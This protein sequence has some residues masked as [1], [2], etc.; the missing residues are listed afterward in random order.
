MQLE[1]ERWTLAVGQGLFHYE[2]VWL[3]GQQRPLTIIYDAGTLSARG[4]NSSAIASVN[5][6]HERLKDKSDSTLD[7][8][9]L[10]HFHADH[11]NLFDQVTKEITV[12]Y[13]IAPLLTPE[14]NFFEIETIAATIN[15]KARLK[16]S[17]PSAGRTKRLIRGLEDKGTEG[18]IDVL[19]LNKRN[20][21][22][23]M[24]LPKPQVILLTDK[25]NEDKS[26]N[27]EII[28]H[29]FPD[30]ANSP[31]NPLIIN[32]TQQIDVSSDETHKA[33]W[34]LAF[35]YNKPDDGF[36][37]LNAKARKTLIGL[38][39]KS[40]K[41]KLDD[42][43]SAEKQHK[44]RPKGDP[45]VEAHTETINKIITDKLYKPE[46]L[47]KRGVTFEDIYGYKD[48]NMTSIALYSGAAN[49]S[50][51]FELRRLYSGSSDES[52]Y[53][54][55]NLI[56]YSHDNSG[57]NK[58]KNPIACIEDDEGKESREEQLHHYYSSDWIPVSSICERDCYWSWMGLGD[59]NFDKD[60]L[61][62]K[63]IKH[64][65]KLIKRVGCCAAPHHGSRN[66]FA[67]REIPAL[68]QGAICLLSCDPYRKRYHHPHAEAMNSIRSGGMIPVLVT[69]RIYTTFHEIIKWK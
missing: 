1:V 43:R 19:S 22:E 69:K 37:A 28:V 66:G 23:R 59:L 41:T 25:P 36:P 2:E 44:T 31:G 26:S 67:T 45:Y 38:F 5:F 51:Q 4:K 47:L 61:V 49:L 17:W 68:M 8:L 48:M 7:Y 18:F 35:Y 10:S 62:K 16:G 64:F 29:E 13:F 24:D 58:K 34:R 15:D 42:Y 55:E 39:L 20:N 27:P 6:V 63:F 65:C 14:D 56:C 54:P 30:N 40:A 52:T 33:F 60:Q 50:V 3:F 12:R 32:H 11:F 21:R 46:E 53:D 9:I 57:S